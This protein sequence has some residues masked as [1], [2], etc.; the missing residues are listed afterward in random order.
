MHLEHDRNAQ[1]NHHQ[2]TRQK[3][4]HHKSMMG[5]FQQGGGNFTSF[6]NLS[7]QPF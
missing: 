4:D 2:D 7:L 6:G 3:V 5:D 1:A